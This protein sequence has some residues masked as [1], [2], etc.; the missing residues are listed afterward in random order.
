MTEDWGAILVVDD[1]ADM[2]KLAYDLLK[3]GGHHV[4]TAGSGEEALKRLAERDYAVVL[5]DFRMKGMEGLELLTQIKRTYPEI[6]VI[7]M[8]GFASVETA[9]ETMKH[10]ASDYLTKPVKKDELVRVVEWMNFFSE[11]SAFGR[12]DRIFGY[13]GMTP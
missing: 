3:D 2:R 8:T 9:V 4:T 13:L 5:T 11:N 12:F 10:G 1:D 6:N 7:L